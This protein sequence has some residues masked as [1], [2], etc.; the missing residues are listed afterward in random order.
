[1]VSSVQKAGCQTY[2]PSTKPGRMTRKSQEKTSVWRAL[3][4]P[5]H[6]CETNTA[7]RLEMNSV[8]QDKRRKLLPPTTDAEGS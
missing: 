1:V 3:Q 2:R 5:A 8:E 6:K 7:L 4:Q